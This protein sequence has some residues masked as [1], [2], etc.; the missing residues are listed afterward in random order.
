ML[1]LASAS[2]VRTWRDHITS[3]VSVPFIT[4]F[5]GLLLVSEI[6]V[7]NDLVGRGVAQSEE[8]KFHGFHLFSMKDE[9]F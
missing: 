8:A 7:G 1:L 4:R 6:Q 3:A 2:V 5:L 9:R